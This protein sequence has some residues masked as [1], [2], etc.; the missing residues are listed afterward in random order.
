MPRPDKEASKQ[1]GKEYDV[2]GF[3]RSNQR[4]PEGSREKGS[5]FHDAWANYH[6][7]NECGEGARQSPSREFGPRG[8]G[9]ANTGQPSSSRRP[10]IDAN[11]S[12][13]DLLRAALLQVLGST[14][15]G[16][17]KVKEADSLKFP[18][19][20]RPEN[21]RKWKTPVREEIRASS[22]KPDEAWTWL[23]DVYQDRPGRFPKTPTRAL[24]TRAVRHV[25]YQDPCAA[26]SC[27][28]GRLRNSNPQLQRGRGCKWQG[29][30]WK[31]DTIHV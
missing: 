10:S 11:T 19:F 20:P 1:T 14:R 30:S 27:C 31:A 28:K 25:G 4:E 22:D 3:M 17:P 7:P 29:R 23:M 18:E 24:G 9:N 8:G 15:P 13:E 2:P 21:Y 26:F 12:N 16:A 6:G 5:S